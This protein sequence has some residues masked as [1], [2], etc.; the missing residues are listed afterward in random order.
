MQKLEGRVAVVTGA[1]SGIGRGLARAF[2]QAG[3]SVALADLD[4][5]ALNTL[6]EELALQGTCA[7]AVPT[8]VS[9]VSDVERLAEHVV[10]ELGAA[11]VLC[12]NAGV[13]ARGGAPWLISQADWE[14]I[15]GV[16]FMGVVHGTR[17]FTPILLEQEEGH[18]V[19]TA[20][21][22][23]LVVGA[24]GNAAYGATKHAVVALSEAT[25]S[26]LVAR[27][28][29]VRVSVLCPGPVNTNI[30][31]TT[32]KLDPSGDRPADSEDLVAR[33][34]RAAMQRWL[35]EDGLSPEHVAR[36]VVDAIRREVFYVLPHDWNEHIAARMQ[37]ILD[38]RSPQ[39]IEG[40][41]ELLRYFQ[42][43]FAKLNQSQ[44]R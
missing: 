24:M 27:G 25:H 7:I 37:N 9:K 5:A 17:V 28:A 22:A 29:R 44:T 26:G 40:P 31:E 41:P 38:R 3:M 42:E 35:A 14:W 10:R 34:M 2:S 36:L 6:Q 13:A 23:G 43:E 11:H 4:A 19:N 33:A 16:N 8:D 20:S 12:N 32:R 15:V 21:L 39:P 1:A 18:I 30:L